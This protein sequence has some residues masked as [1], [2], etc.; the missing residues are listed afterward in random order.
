MAAPSALLC[1]PY[2]T[3]LLSLA[4]TFKEQD[5]EISGSLEEFSRGQ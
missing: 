5:L 4:L 3:L 2:M 1:Q